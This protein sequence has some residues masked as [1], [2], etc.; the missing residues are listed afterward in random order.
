VRAYRRAAMTIEQLRG[1]GEDLAGKITEICRTGRSAAGLAAIRFG[2]GQAR[3]GWIEPR[4]SDA[5]RQRALRATMPL[6]D[7]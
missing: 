3:R 7:I 1:I 6:P 2:I 5:E 4:D